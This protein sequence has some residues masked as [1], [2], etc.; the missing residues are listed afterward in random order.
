MNFALF[1]KTPPWITPFGELLAAVLFL[2]LIA[3]ITIELPY[4]KQQKQKAA[5]KN[6]T[7][8]SAYVLEVQRLYPSLLELDIQLAFEQLRIYF[9]ICWACEGKKVVMPSKIVDVCWHVFILDTRNYMN[10]CST[11]F[12]GYL[13]HELPLK[14]V[15]ESDVVDSENHLQFLS[16]VRAFQGASDIEKN[17]IPT[18][19]RIDNNLQIEDGQCYSAEYLS[20]L[21]S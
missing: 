4:R 9:Q 1:A 2:M 6:W 19:F 16:I 21:A 15:I 18:L 17:S 11:V 10:F 14:T 3:G 7:F 13:H 12:D 8:N 5:L 20:T